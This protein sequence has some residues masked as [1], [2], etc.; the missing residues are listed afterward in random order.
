MSV[1]SRS[2]AAVGAGRPNQVGSGRPFLSDRV[3]VATPRLS[4]TGFTLPPPFQDVLV[5]P[6]GHQRLAGAMPEHEGGVEG[7]EQQAGRRVMRGPRVEPGLRCGR[8][9]R[10]ARLCDRQG[11]PLREVARVAG[12]VAGAVA[13]A[14]DRERLV[15]VDGR[16]R[17]GRV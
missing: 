10:P 8:V 5:V 7:G 15:V 17:I 3:P 11:G 9:E 13:G 1:A 2:S 4:A 6:G 14:H 16:R 12:S